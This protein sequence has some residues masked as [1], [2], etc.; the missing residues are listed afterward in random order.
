MVALGICDIINIIIIIALHIHYWTITSIVTDHNGVY[1]CSITTRIRLYALI[2]WI[3]VSAMTSLMFDVIEDSMNH[4]SKW[5]NPQSGRAATAVT[6]AVQIVSKPPIPAMGTHFTVF[7][8]SRSCG[9]AGRLALFLLKAGD[10]HTYPCPTTSHKLVWIFGICYEQMH[11]RMQ[12]S[13]RCNRIEYGVHL[14]GAG[15]HQIQYTHL[16]LPSTQRIRIIIL[17]HTDITPP[18]PSNPCSKTP[19]KSQHTPSTSPQP[20][21]RQTPNIPLFPQDM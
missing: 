11:V 8:T 15:I 3:G 1:W 14:R 18:H 2:L 21:H 12:I 19:T 4:G 16:V 9:P 7:L 17:Y 6:A 13:I 5:H 20:K 10:I